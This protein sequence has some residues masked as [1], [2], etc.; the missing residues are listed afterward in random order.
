ML[1][2]DMH[3]TDHFFYNLRKSKSIFWG[4]LH[5]FKIFYHA[6]CVPITFFLIDKN[7]KNYTFIFHISSNNV[8]LILGVVHK[9]L[10]KYLKLTTGPNFFGQFL[11]LHISGVSVNYLD[12][13]L[14]NHIVN[15]IKTASYADV[16][17]NV[18]PS[19]LNPLHHRFRKCNS[20]NR[21]N[22]HHASAQNRLFVSLKLVHK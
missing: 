21:S 10:S 3:I 2:G 16:Y 13:I 1:F 18:H 6:E 15:T 5:I 22:F 9:N 19:G 20:C 17:T 7:S 8:S 11:Y 14:N 12:I 4:K